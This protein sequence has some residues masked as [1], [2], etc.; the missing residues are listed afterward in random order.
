[1]VSPKGKSS[2]QIFFF[3]NAGPKDGR[4]KSH[5]RTRHVSYYLLIQ[6]RLSPLYRGAPIIGGCRVKKARLIALLAIVSL[7]AGCAVG[8][9]YISP[10]LEL[11]A[12]WNDRKAS[13][14]RNHL[15]SR[16]G[17]AT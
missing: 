5:G 6:P 1:M 10:S 13:E 14:R 16:N 17:G 7:L 9:D 4:N 2:S 11:P 12:R 3:V 8:P 15:S